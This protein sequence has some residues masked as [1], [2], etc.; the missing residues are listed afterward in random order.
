VGTAASLK[1]PVDLPLDV[2]HALDLQ[3]RVVEISMEALAFTPP[4]R[5]DALVTQLLDAADVS[6]DD[7]GAT[8][9]YLVAA[10]L[11]A[12]L[13]IFAPSASG[14][15]AIDRYF[16]NHPPKDA[17]ESAAANALRR[18]RFRIVR[19]DRR[20]GPN[21]YQGTDL[22][23]N[24]TITFCH[25]LDDDDSV[26]GTHIAARFCPITNGATIMTGAPVPLCDDDLEV[27]RRFFRPNGK[28]LSN[29][30]R[31]AEAVYRNVMSH[32]GVMDA[33]PDDLEEQLDR[34]E[35][36]L[37]E[38]TPPRHDPPRHDPFDPKLSVVSEIAQRWAGLPAGAEPSAADIGHARG[39]TSVDHIVDAIAFA[40]LAADRG[41]QRLGDAYTRVATILVETMERRKSV[42]PDS[43]SLDEVARMIED[44]I[45][46][47]DISPAARSRFADLRRQVGAASVRRDGAKL[48][49]ANLDRLLQVIRGLRAKTVDQGCTE[50]E[51]M[52][53]AAKVAELLDRYGLSLS[54]VDLGK[55]SCDG[56]TIDTDRRR[57]GP[58]DSVIQHIA[59][60]FDCRCWIEK[61]RA[62]TIRHV[63]FGLPGDVEAAQY[64]HE[65]VELTFESETRAF[66]RGA[67]YGDLHSSEKRGGTTS[68]HLGLANGI[69]TKLTA[70]RGERE[71]AMHRSSGRDLMVV[72]ASIVDEELDKLG[73]SFKSKS[74]SGKKYV[75]RD[76]YT[77]GQEAGERFEYTQGIAGQG[78]GE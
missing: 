28:G 38:P 30:E 64:L 54:D 46:S 5:S 33:L 8:K 6:P 25:D 16:R 75:L 41:L 9:Y 48:D 13:A 65:L 50:A 67:F 32:G 60:F 66:K 71:A 76:A 7:P 26:V 58:I 36:E 35:A 31:C 10:T 51:A 44:H 1:T 4:K 37:F 42:R 53:A 45:R 78:I 62:E 21:L 61:T 55:Q 18:A 14:S 11:A 12:D 29:S 23:T 73:M 22:A 57:S 49:D 24:E 19:I 47:G 2:A 27:A 15:T 69:I 74:A 34:I 43:P 63:L 70:I 56:V 3:A 52:A 59:A 72:K 20:D 68:F 40:G 39:L 77:A 17:D